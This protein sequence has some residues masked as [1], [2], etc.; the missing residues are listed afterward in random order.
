MVTL[1]VTGTPSDGA[2]SESEKIVSPFASFSFTTVI[3][4]ADVTTSVTV[5]EAWAL[6]EAGVPSLSV[7]VTDAV[8]G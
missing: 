8:F 5:T 4:Y 6:S 2:C 7:T 3:G 1:N